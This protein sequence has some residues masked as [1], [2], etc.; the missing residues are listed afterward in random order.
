MK[1]ISALF[2]VLCLVISICAC[3]SNATVGDTQTTKTVKDEKEDF[4]IGDEIF[5]QNSEG[6]Y[7]FTITGV[8]ETNDRNQF[9]EKNPNRVIIISYSYENISQASDL[10]LSDM[11]FKAYDSDNNAMDTYPASVDYP[12]S[13][14]SGRKAS[15]QM[16]FGL[17]S[18][19]N[20]IE[21]EFYDNMFMDSDCKIIL[22]W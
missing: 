13:I 5:I 1:K 4:K 6:E 19:K 2:L 8:E 10:Y 12:D 11:N 9:A 21:L 14:S 20:Y 16:A 22:E 3:A 15:G 18:E 17:D 7:K